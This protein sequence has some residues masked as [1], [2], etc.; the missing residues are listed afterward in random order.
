MSLNRNTGQKKGNNTL[1]FIAGTL[2]IILL[3]LIFWGMS[4]NSSIDQLIQSAA[5]DSSAFASD[6]LLV[7][8]NEMEEAPEPEEEKPEKPV[9]ATVSDTLATPEPNSDS[10]VKGTP[11]TETIPV[12]NPSVS[13]EGDQVV[14]GY[15]IRKGDT[16]Y[17]LAAKFGN[18]PAD[19]LAL[20]GLTDMSVQADKTIKVK[21]K[22]LHA[23][24]PGEGLNSIAEKYGVAAKSIKIANDLKDETIPEGSKLL[25]PLK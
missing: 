10:T 20:N 21:V 2:A 3:G 22:A 1:F 18:K 4:K 19:I 5:P 6:S 24:S 25:I 17:K 7:A 12:M 13:T 16:M 9:V 23:V 15:K 11:N 14:Y 8:G